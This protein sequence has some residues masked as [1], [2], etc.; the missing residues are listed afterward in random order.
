MKSHK[1]RFQFYQ[2]KCRG[3]ERFGPV[4]HLEMFP[5]P[6]FCFNC[7][8]LAWVVNQYQMFAE[9]ARSYQCHTIANL[10]EDHGAI[11]SYG[12]DEGVRQ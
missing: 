10:I 9:L 1:L 7:L 3:C 12:I 8:G 2:G 4:H 5:T 11:I 6:A